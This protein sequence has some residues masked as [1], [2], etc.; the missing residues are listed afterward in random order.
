MAAES[1]FDPYVLGIGAVMTAGANI[2]LAIFGRGPKFLPPLREINLLQRAAHILSVG[3][4]LLTYQLGYTAAWGSLWE[5]LAWT[6]AAFLISFLLYFLLMSGLTLHCDSDPTLYLGGLWKTGAA[7]QRLREAREAPGKGPTSASEYFCNN[8]RNAEMIWSSASRLGAGALLLLGY[9]ALVFTATSAVTSAWMLASEQQKPS[10]A[11][12]AD[13]GPMRTELVTLPGDPL[14]AFG[15]ADL[16]PEAEELLEDLA[17]RLRR[18]RPTKI[19]ISGHTDAIGSIAANQKLS[20]RRAAAVRDW[21]VSK[22]CLGGIR[23]D[24]RGYG[25]TRS[26]APNWH[27][28]GSDDPIGRALNRRVEISY[29]SGKAQL[30]TLPPCPG[31]NSK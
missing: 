8:G 7:R 24:A 13:A 30:G 21:L 3:V 29:K 25:S 10:P 11:P 14:F 18:E 16:T 31:K 6:L 1:L 5:M 12:P 2:Y 23:I 19:D 15:K 17:D 28:D 22:T 26:I 4:M 27:Q 9:V 20:E